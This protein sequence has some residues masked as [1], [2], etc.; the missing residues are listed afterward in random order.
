MTLGKGGVVSLTEPMARG[1]MK[2][3]RWGCAGMRRP[4]IESAYGM[5]TA[6]SIYSRMGIKNPRKHQHFQGP[7]VVV[8]AGFEPATFRL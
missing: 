4:C 3:G 6:S 1:R 7:E 5:L 8:G 2:R